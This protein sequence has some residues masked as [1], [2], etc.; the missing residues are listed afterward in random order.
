VESEVLA[1]Y[2]ENPDFTELVRHLTVAF[3]DPVP[4]SPP[5][6]LPKQPYLQPP[7]SILVIERRAFGRTVLVG[8]HI[9]SHMVRFIL[10]GHE[11]PPEE[12]G[13]E[14]DGKTEGRREGEGKS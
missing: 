13:E 9:V 7:L 1:S 8:S 11:D 6:D 4:L 3:R 5:Q 10:W 14:E 12:E 2:H